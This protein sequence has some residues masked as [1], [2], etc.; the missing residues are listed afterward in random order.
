MGYAQR[1]EQQNEMRFG[2]GEAA[3]SKA[4]AS[5]R[6]VLRLEDLLEDVFEYVLAEPASLRV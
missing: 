1:Q 3:T 6:E 4:N 2:N 5:Q